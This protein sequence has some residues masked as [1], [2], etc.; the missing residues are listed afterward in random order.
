MKNVLVLIL[1]CLAL[2]CLPQQVEPLIFRE[3]T[4]DFG[5]IDEGKGNADHEFIFTNNSGRPVKIVSVQASCGCTTPGWSQNP[6]PQAK[7]GFIRASFDPR[8]RPGYFNKTLTVTTDWDANPI[9]LQ[10]KGHVF[11]EGTAGSHDFSVA[12]GNL[13]FISR[14]FNVGKVFINRSATEK[15]FAVMNKGTAPIK[16]LKVAKPS[17]I[18]IGMTV[19][20]APQEKGFISVLFD[21]QQKNQFGFASDNIQI[22]TD[23]VGHEIKSISVF[24]SLEEYYSIPVGEEATKAP[25]L[26]LKEQDIDLGRFRQRDL[27]D[28]IIT[29]KNTGKRDIQ[30]KAIQSNCTCISTEL[31]KKIIFPGDSSILKISFRPQNRGGTQLK[32]ITLYSNDS[33]NPVQR[34]NVQVYIED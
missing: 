3:K 16:F 12:N 14:S 25:I 4:Y 23:D 10:I 22:T 26:F 27:I 7:T 5:D 15:Q 34:I 21:G 17:Y 31:E 6:I 32:A 30:I 18:K 1:M 2:P 33:R 13:Y 28:R 8:G 29:L 19:S 24:A 20:L 11:N 9:V